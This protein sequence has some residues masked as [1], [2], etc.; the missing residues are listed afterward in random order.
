M[1]RN[2]VFRGLVWLT[3]LIFMVTLPMSVTPVQAEPGATYFFALKAVDDVGNPSPLSNSPQGTTESM[4]RMIGPG[5]LF[6]ALG[7]NL[8]FDPPKSLV[9]K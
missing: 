7:I 5:M 6:N 3:L 8:S 1:K 9:S 2:R 4:G